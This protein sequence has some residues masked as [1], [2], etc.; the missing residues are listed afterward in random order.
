MPAVTVLMSCYNASRYLSEAVES[1]LAQSY[2]DYEFIVVNDGSTDDTSGMLRKYAAEDDRIVLVEKENTGLGDSLNAGMR[3]ARG[4][5]IARLDADDI[6]LPD[7]LARQ[8]AFVQENDSVVLLGTGCFLINECGRLSR[9][10]RYPREHHGLMRHMESGC[11]PFPHSSALF[12]K[13]AV[14]ASGG[15]NPRFIR[16]QDYDLWLTLGETREIACLQ[17]P[18]VEIRKHASNISCD[19]VHPTQL[20]MAMAARVCHFLRLREASDPSRTK[21]NDEWNGFISWLTTRLERESYLGIQGQRA[22]IRHGL[23]A[24]LQS[25]GRPAVSR[26]ASATLKARCV[27]Q[28]VRDRFLWMN[29]ALRLADEWIRVDGDSFCCQVE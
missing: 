3:M 25:A 2:R 14:I 26:I 20:I 18:L 16:A 6:A 24:S 9:A 21:R 11:S 7:R 4:E 22:G 8:I 29:L 19:S 12:H 13:A 5:W 10:Y 23:H 17:D 27:Y 28:V 1:V 15:Y